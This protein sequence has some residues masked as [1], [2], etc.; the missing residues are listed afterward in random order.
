MPAFNPVLK[1]SGVP[2]RLYGTTLALVNVVGAVAALKAHKLIARFGERAAILF[3]P[4]S[5]VFMFSLLAFLRVPAVVA[6]F[7]IQGAVFGAYPLVVRT[8]LNRNVASAARR[9]TVISLE[10]MACRVGF[11]VLVAVSGWCLEWWDLK[12]TIAFV[13]TAGCIPFV[14]LALT[15]RT[16]DRRP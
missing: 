13:A 6:L 1:A 4:L 9:A 10:S 5:L 7:C 11:G 14:I 16:A 8:I 3:M 2:V 15:R 12:Y